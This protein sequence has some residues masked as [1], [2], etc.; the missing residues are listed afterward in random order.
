M[1]IAISWKVKWYDNRDPIAT[2]VPFVFPACWLFYDP[3]SRIL[4]DV[5]EKNDAAWY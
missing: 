2:A 5:W 3:V 4:L 1:K